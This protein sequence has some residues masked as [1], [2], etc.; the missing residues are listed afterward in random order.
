MRNAAPCLTLLF[1][2]AACSA[3]RTPTK[4]TETNLPVPDRS[5]LDPIKPPPPHVGAPPE[6]PPAAGASTYPGRALVLAEWRKA[7]NRA[8][9]AP[10]AFRADGPIDG[11]PRRANFSGGWAV[12]FDLPNLRSAYGLAGPGIIPQDKADFAAQVDRITR[13]WPLIRR[14]DSSGNLPAGSIAGYGL[15]GAKPYAGPA[16]QGSGQ[17]SLAYVRIPGQTCTYNVWTRL[18]RD[19]L[20]LL[21]DNLAL[22]GD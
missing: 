10:L 11:T 1:A 4:E 21:L 18:G 9:C 16:P 5:A 3:D 13:Q 22:V 2:L 7:D 17:Q 8:D 12:A 15:Q 6:V 14:W 19:H 20:E